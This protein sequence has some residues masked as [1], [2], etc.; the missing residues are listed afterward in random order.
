MT[1]SLERIFLD[2]CVYGCD[3]VNGKHYGLTYRDYWQYRTLTYSQ[4]VT[5]EMLFVQS[6]YRK[7]RSL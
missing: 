5:F 3:V 7:I 6:L 2:G 4:G 1:H